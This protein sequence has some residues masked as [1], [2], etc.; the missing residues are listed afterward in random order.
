MAKIYHYLF[1]YLVV[2]FDALLYLLCCTC[3]C[4]VFIYFLVIINFQFLLSI[5]SLTFSSNMCFIYLLMTLFHHLFVD[6]LDYQLKSKE[7][8]IHVNRISRRSKTIN[9][10][11]NTDVYVKGPYIYKLKA[12]N[13]CKRQC[14]DIFSF[15]GL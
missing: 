10:M 11:F 12:R 3:Y 8:Q 6:V 5:F 9:L 7:Y 2:N 14:S 4:I 1:I 13:Y 15:C